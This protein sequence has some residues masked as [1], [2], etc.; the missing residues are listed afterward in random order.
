MRGERLKTSCFLLLSG[1]WIEI[2]FIIF[3]LLNFDSEQGYDMVWNKLVSERLLPRLFLNH[4]RLFLNHGEWDC[5]KNK[6]RQSQDV[7]AGLFNFRNFV[8][9]HISWSFWKS[10][11]RFSETSIQSPFETI[12]KFQKS[13]LVCNYDYKSMRSALPNQLK[14]KI[15][16]FSTIQSIFC[17]DISVNVSQEIKYSVTSWKGPWIRVQSLH[18]FCDLEQVM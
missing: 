5:L 15:E 12:F 9:C 14:D 4:V 1:F 18:N 11:G 17:W 6:L 2:P 8:N 13:G 7:K 16:M 3:L 10:S